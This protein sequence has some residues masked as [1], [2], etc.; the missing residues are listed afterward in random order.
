MF[1][2][3]VTFVPAQIEVP[4]FA[5]MLIVGV[6]MGLTVM[7]MLLL[8]SVVGTAQV[9]ALVNSQVM[10]SPL[11]SELL[12]S[13]G[14]LVPVGTPL[15]FQTK[16]GLPPPLVTLAVKVTV[17]PT[18]MEF[19]GLLL[20]EI[21]GVTVGVTVMEMLLL[22]TDK[23]DAHPE[24]LCSSQVT[25]SPGFRP[26]VVKVEELAPIGEPLTFQMNVG[27]VPPLVMEAVKVAGCPAQ[28][29]LLGVEMTM[30]GLVGTAH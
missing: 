28:I 9:A 12:T 13:V 19:P 18:Q 21:V 27:V 14:E 29:V 7:T 25:I 17:V 1:A 16:P 24:L 22:V 3:N 5:L 20:M 6:T 10:T 23:G 30:V 11:L 2:V 15:I 8:V 26:V 4:V